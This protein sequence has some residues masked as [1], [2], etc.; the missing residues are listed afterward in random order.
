MCPS[1]FAKTPLMLVVAA[2]LVVCAKPV[3][4]PP[5]GH[6]AQI[7]LDGAHDRLEG[8][9]YLHYAVGIHIDAPP[10]VVWA[11]LTDAPGYTSWS[12]T[13]VRLEGDMSLDGS[14]ALV[15]QADRDRT[16]DLT[17][18]GLYAPHHMMWQHGDDTFE[19]VRTF[20]LTGS[21]GGT[22]FTM[23]KVFTGSKLPKMAPELPDYGPGFDAFARD[24]EAE[25][26]RR[27]PTAATAAAGTPASGPVQPTHGTVAAEPTRSEAPE[28]PPEAVGELTC[29]SKAGANLKPRDGCVTASISCDETVRGHS[30]GAGDSHFDA[31]FYQAKYCAV[32]SDTY[33]N[34]ERIYRFKMPSH[35]QATVALESPCEDLDLFVLQWTQPGCPTRGA[36]V[37]TCDASTRDGSGRVELESIKNP[38]EFL[39]VVEGKNGVHA[40]FDLTVSCRGK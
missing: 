6:D 23:K 16:F 9:Q 35:S 14:L 8:D 21:R 10:E 18:T 2:L 30:R 4:P 33:D 36:S 40:P 3:P 13:V 31:R 1:A 34:G 15:V 19:G 26:E 11:I 27:A 24:L 12:S 28:P 25:A 37:G 32:T 39:L 22:R 29:D 38:R 20:N 7:E 17:V 5:A